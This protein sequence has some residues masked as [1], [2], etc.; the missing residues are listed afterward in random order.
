MKIQC[1]LCKEIVE[2]GSFRMSMSGIE[3]DCGACAGHFFVKAAGSGRSSGDS[4]VRESGGKSDRGVV[5][6]CPKCR[7]VQD[8][9][10]ACRECGLRTELFAEFR[11]RNDRGADT[12]FDT[13]FAECDANW[14]DQGRHAKLV[15]A[16]SAAL[17]FS[18][19]ARFYR[20]RLA[21]R[22]GDTIAQKQLT[23]LSRMAEA[24]FMSRAATRSIGDE[25]GHPYKNVLLML[26][27]LLLVGAAGV[28]L[29]SVM[30]VPVEASSGPSFPDPGFERID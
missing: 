13:L 11:A 25:S 2:L 16:A 30:K 22:P 24:T 14:Q 5:M 26:L 23:R 29:N 18:P 10:S 20:E 1:E 4:V 15:E 28:G 17:A 19:V 3:I 9:H 21:H 6:R 7:R 8:L 27:V 12:Q